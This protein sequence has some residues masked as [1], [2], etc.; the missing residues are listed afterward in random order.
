M[1]D[2]VNPRPRVVITFPFSIYPVQSGGALRGFFLLR[3]IARHFETTAIVPDSADAIRE[4]IRAETGSEDFEVHQIE[5]SSER[6]GLVTRLSERIRMARLVGSFAVPTNAVLLAIA[7]L[8]QDV[9]QHRK[10]A[11]VVLSNLELAPC[12]KLLRRLDRDI[13]RVVDMSNIEHTLLGHMLESQGQRPENN[14][15]WC[16]LKRDE[17]SLHSAVDGLFAC[18]DDDSEH[19]K[20]L[21]SGRIECRTVPNGVDS[22]G[23]H[24]HND[25][26]KHESRDILFCGTLSYPPNV[27]AIN[28][29]VSD[30]FPTV[31]ERVPDARIRI[32]GRHFD[33]KLY[34]GI[35]QHA[36]VDVIG[37]VDSVEPEYQRCGITICPLRMGSGTRLKILESMSLG[38]PMV[39]T[40]LGCEGINVTHGQTIQIADDAPSFAEEV[41]SLMNDPHS[42]HTLRKSA[43]TFVE[44]NYDWK[45]VGT[46]AAATLNEWISKRQG[47]QR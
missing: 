35:S 21:N 5:T 28:W 34:P 38:N 19:L 17:E 41:I 11:A 45:V 18:S 20:R 2:E 10:P 3:E 46:K 40:S 7:D 16:R 14:A 25:E 32:V 30:I 47:D 27:D 43:R 36:S 26:T 22:E 1:P 37:E 6:R 8:M 24:F 29:F 13:T 9:V 33:E 31:L 44:E 12:G 42:F 4:A 39:T 23:L 15:Q